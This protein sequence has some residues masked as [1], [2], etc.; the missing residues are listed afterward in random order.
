M[1]GS[2]QIIFTVNANDP[3]RSYGFRLYAGGIVLGK[4]A[5][6]I[7]AQGRLRFFT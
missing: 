4:R 1:D 3:S 7:T 5:W 2:S 6:V